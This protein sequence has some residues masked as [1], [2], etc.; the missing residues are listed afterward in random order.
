MKQLIHTDLISIYDL[1]SGSIDK[2]IPF[3]L[4]NCNFHGMMLGTPNLIAE[5]I[6]NSKCIKSKKW[7]DTNLFDTRMDLICA[8]D[9]GIKH[10]IFFIKILDNTKCSKN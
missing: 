9:F 1:N 6:P 7:I 8:I 3:A 2:P 5:F 4:S 10:N